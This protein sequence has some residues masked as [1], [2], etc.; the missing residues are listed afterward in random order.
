MRRKRRAA[1]FLSG[2][3][4]LLLGTLVLFPVLYTLTSSL[5]SPSEVQRYYAA[6]TQTAGDAAGARLHL[7]PDIFSLESFYQ[8]L[9]RRPDY[10]IKFWNSLLLCGAIVA[11]Q[12][13]VS[14]MGGF[15][16]AKYRFR[17]RTVL[18]Y[19]LIVLMMMPVQVTLVPNYIVLDRLR[20]IDTWWALVLPAAF[21]PFGTFLMTQIFR[22]VPDEIVDAARLD[23]ASTAGVLARVLVPAGKGGAIS[24]VLLSFIDAWNMVEQ[25][26]VFLSDPIRYPLSVFLATVSQQNFSLSFACGVL[27]MMPVLL[28]FLFFNEELV[29]GIEFSGIK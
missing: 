21:L 23:G 20:L 2:A 22:G 16:F 8:V 26:M 14:C 9:L 13:V 28:L 12:L 10:L 17:G 19:L 3:L 25:P 6:I 15:A 18:F 7:L 5:M 4:F 1:N 27:A 29:E 24:L 11:G